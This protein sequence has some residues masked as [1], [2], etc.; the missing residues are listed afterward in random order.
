MKLV[1]LLC[2]C[3]VSSASFVEAAQAARETRL[4]VVVFDPDRK[5]VV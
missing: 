5:S 4:R 1:T 2:A 3:L